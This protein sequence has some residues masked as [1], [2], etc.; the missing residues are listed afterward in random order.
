MPWS[1]GQ[2]G[3]AY[4]LRGRMP[5]GTGVSC[6]IRFFGSGTRHDTPGV[7]QFNIPLARDNISPPWY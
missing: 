4:S 7:K 2:L 1:N 3:S 6:A 5:A